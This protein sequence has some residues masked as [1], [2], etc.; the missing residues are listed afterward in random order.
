MQ[1]VNVPEA[2]N[3]MQLISLFFIELNTH[4]GEHFC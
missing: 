2:G 4:V 1:E 3:F